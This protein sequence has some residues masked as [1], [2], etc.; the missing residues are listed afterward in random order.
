MATP[1]S[2][3]I[4]SPVFPATT[5]RAWPDIVS[6]LDR[7]AIHL[8]RVDLSTASSSDEGC[9]TPDEVTRAN[10]Y[11]VEPPRRRFRRCRT[12]L[13]HCLSALTGAAPASLRFGA[14]KF[15]KP[16]LVDPDPAGLV[17]NVSHTGDW[18]VIAFGWSRELGVDIETI[19]PRLDGL[20][21]AARFFSTAE[22]TALSSLPAAYQAAGFYRLWTSK[23]AYMKGVG[24]GMS[25]PLGS[26]TMRADPTAEPAL[27]EPLSIERPWSA[28]GFLVAEHVPGVVLWEGP[29]RPVACW[30]AATEW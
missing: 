21:L 12:A 29:D 26:F 20:A 28:R 3:T 14:E 13:R 23:E 19:D 2:V 4:S 8:V 7:D 25:L 30:N 5:W 18:G 16:I 17:F 9:L 6:S 24:L 10:R 1:S 22:Q 27:L 11:V 15:G